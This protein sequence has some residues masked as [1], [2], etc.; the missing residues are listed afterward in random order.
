MRAMLNLHGILQMVSWH[1][2]SQVDYHAAQASGRLLY[3]TVDL[4]SPHCLKYI[5]IIT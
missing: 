2:D 5:Y 4:Y 1:I 3:Q